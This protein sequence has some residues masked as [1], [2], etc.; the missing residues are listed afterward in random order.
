MRNIILLAVQAAGKGTLARLL[1]EKYG[2]AN[3]SMGEV[4]RN[5]RNDGSERAKMIADCQDKGILVPFDI[6]LELIQERISQ[7][8]CKNGYILDGFPR[9]LKQAEA[10]DHILET[11]GKDIGVE[12]NLTIPEHLIYERIAGRRTCKK[13][14]RSYNINSS[15]FRP[16]QENVC[17]D[18]G[19][20]LYQRSDDTEEAIRV[21]VETYFKS[22]APLIDYYRNKGVLY[23]VESIDSDETLKNVEK[24]LK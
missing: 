3:I 13:C 14:G 10:Y 19:G 15:K 21:R 5:A 11:I 7:P 22:T 17:D 23:E 9:D 18:C 24:I 12:I 20:E 2:Y 1:S 4:M 16:L 6:T 8:D